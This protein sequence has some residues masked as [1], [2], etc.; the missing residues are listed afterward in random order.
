MVTCYKDDLQDAKHMVT[1]YVIIYHLLFYVRYAGPAQSISSFLGHHLPGDR[2]VTRRKDHGLDWGAKL[3]SAKF[4]RP[5][6][7]TA[8][9]RTHSR[10]VGASALPCRAMAW[11]TLLS[12]SSSASRHD[13]GVCTH[14]LL[15]LRLPCLLRCKRT[16]R[17]IKSLQPF[18]ATHFTQ[19]HFTTWRNIARCTRCKLLRIPIQTQRSSSRKHQRQVGVGLL[20]LDTRVH[21]RTWCDVGRKTR[22]ATIRNV[23]CTPELLPKWPRI[24]CVTGLP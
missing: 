10:S 20:I 5:R 2:Y 3:W 11:T 4:A 15:Q 17:F 21:C 19:V 9:E 14:S 8:M 18:A 22:K 13:I 23:I 6:A 16:P 7:A 12:A 1:Y 24:D